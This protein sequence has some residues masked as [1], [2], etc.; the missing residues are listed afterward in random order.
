M[1][2][3]AGQRWTREKPTE[4][5]WY[6]VRSLLGGVEIVSIG[7]VNGVLRVYEHGCDTGVKMEY[8]SSGEWQGPITPNEAT[9]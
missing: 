8:L 1:T 3:P 2:T 4:P 6:W 7:C 9:E 5:G